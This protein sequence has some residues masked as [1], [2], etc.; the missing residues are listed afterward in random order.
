MGLELF[1]DLITESALYEVDSTATGTN[2]YISGP[3]FM[4][5]SVNRNK[6]LYSS[7]KTLPAIH[8]YNENWVKARRALGELDHPDYPLPSRHNAAIMTKEL[9]F[10]S[11]SVVNGRAIILDKMGADCPGVKV[12]GLLQAGFNMGVSSRATGTAIQKDGYMDI[13]NDLTYTAVDCVDRPSAQIAYVNMMLGESA[14]SGWI[15]K[16][17]V[18]IQE[19]GLQSLNETT[20]LDRETEGEFLSMFEKFLSNI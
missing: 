9:I 2:H 17:G 11:D 16:D 20:R 7:E 8:A 19:K 3:F 15:E 1:H 4:M 6:R 14:T 18:W 12:R 13:Q 10:E 5:N